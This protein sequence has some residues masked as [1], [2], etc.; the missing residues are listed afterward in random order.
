MKVTFIGTGTM[1]SITRCNTSILVDD[2]L[3][4]VGMGTVK[5]IER[6]QI[7]TKN[8]NYIVISHFHADHFLDIPNFLIGRGIRK[9]IDKKLY[10]IGP[11]GVRKKTIELL[12]FTHA[13][14]NINKYDNLEEK[15]NCEFIK[16]DDGEEF[17]TKDFKLTAYE[18]S[19][20]NCK[21]I[22]GYILEKNNK[23]I[24]YATDTGLCDNYYKM[25]D[26]SKYIFSDSTRLES[27]VSH[28]G[29]DAYEGLI[30][31]YPDCKFY[32]IHRSD[33]DTS[34]IDDVYCPVDGEIL[35]I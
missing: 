4:D 9:E 5:Q 35:E 25:C 23:K 12:I 15:Y 31:K 16:I 30:K 33:Y 6:L 10:I 34:K 3:F 11:K 27:S 17:K 14:G 13:D 18:L 1:G 20:G 19:H 8:I 26:K 2:I 24:A 32:A 28:I 22:N 21:P 7:Y 29:I